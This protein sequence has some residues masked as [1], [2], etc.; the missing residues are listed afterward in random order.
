MVGASPKS[1]ASEYLE[2]ED[3]VSS[4]IDPVGEAWWN[5]YRRVKVGMD[6]KEV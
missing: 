3:C 1:S 4:Q 6:A 5:A 2:V